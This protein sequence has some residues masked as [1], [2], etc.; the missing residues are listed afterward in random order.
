MTSSGENVQGQAGIFVGNFSHSLDPKR[1]LTI[2]SEWRAQ[3]TDTKGL[4]VLPDIHQKCLCVF[5]AS[6]MFRRMEKMRQHSFSDARVRQFAR[7]LG[8]QAELLPWD[9]QGRIRIKD[10]L[11]SFAGL[12]DQIELVGTFDSFEL[13]NPDQWKAIGGMDRSSMQEAARYVGF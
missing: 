2:P 13:W 12:V 4:Y 6:E 7:V 11:L 5:Q 8:A 9:S 3:I 10:E 1:R